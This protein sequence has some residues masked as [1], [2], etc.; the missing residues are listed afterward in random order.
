[1]SKQVIVGATAVGAF[2]LAQSFVA[3]IFADA[4]LTITAAAVGFGIGY[5]SGKK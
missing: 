2:V 4:M 3:S 1:M 5:L